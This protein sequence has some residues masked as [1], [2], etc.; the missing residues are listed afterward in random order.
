M[1]NYRLFPSTNGAAAANSYSGTF[2]SGVCFKSLKAGC[3]FLG[4]WW[5]VGT[6]QSVLPVE[7]ALWQVQNSGSGQGQGYIAGSK[8]TSGP[9]STGTWNFVPVATPIPLAPHG[10][11]VAQVGCNGNF[12]DSAGW[13][14][15][16]APN[17]ITSG[18][19]FAFGPNPNQ[20]A[21]TTYFNGGYGC[22]DGVPQGCFNDAGSTDPSVTFAGGASATDCFWVDVEI[23][24]TA[25]TGYNGPYDPYINF[26]LRADP[27]TSGDAPVAYSVALEFHMSEPFIVNFNRYFVPPGT[28]QILATSTD[29]W[30][31][32]TN[33]LTGV[34]VLSNP[35]PVWTDYLGNP[36]T[37]GSGYSGNQ[38]V[39]AAMPSTVLPAGK[40]KVSVY[41]AN[42]ALMGWSGKRL[43]Y[44]SL[45]TNSGDGYNAKSALG[46]NG[47]TNGPLYVPGGSNA[48]ICYSYGATGGQTEPGQAA[49]AYD[50]NNDYPNYYVG[51]NSPGNNLG[52]TYWISL[53]VT[54]TG[55]PPP[56]SGP[57]QYILQRI[58]QSLHITSEP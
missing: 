19:L 49:F 52:Q 16:N 7:C 41:N 14:G 4:Y 9:L 34:K 46:I 17:G 12:P 22:D 28:N 42:G 20:G 40:Y 45:D 39:Q 11:Y 47:F 5:W 6:N 58:K 31:I 44:F 55:P 18:P 53:S 51:V 27:L 33:P 36:V 15:A 29:I 56:A 10:T 24:D 13:W 38:W 1:T 26:D 25:P 8:T 23:S 21:Y 57:M 43:N 2:M 50:G 48:A 37:G 35:S 32:G 54:P 30:A 3:F